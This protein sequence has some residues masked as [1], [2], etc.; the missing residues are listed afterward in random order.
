MTLL[1]APHVAH[2]DCSV[3]LK[4]SFHEDGPRAGEMKTHFGKPIPRGKSLAPCRQSPSQCAKGS[5]ENPKVL[6]ELNRRVFLHWAQC[7]ATGAWP[8]DW[9]VQR[10]AFI[11]SCAY[12]KA[13]KSSG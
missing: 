10:H 4:Y 8:N 1:T 9:F 5:P 3:C 13:G 11:I 6:S 7:N 2:R 12:K